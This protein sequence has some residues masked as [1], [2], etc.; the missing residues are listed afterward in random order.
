MTKPARATKSALKTAASMAAAETARVRRARSA[1]MTYAARVVAAMTLALRRT[2]AR[3]RCVVSAAAKTPPAL[4]VRFALRP[5]VRRVA[6]TTK[7]AD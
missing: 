7:A 1:E 6:G 2:S 4:S 3:T 5:A